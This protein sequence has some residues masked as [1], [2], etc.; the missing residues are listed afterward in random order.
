MKGYKTQVNCKIWVSIYFKISINHYYHF[1]C[2][3][4]SSVQTRNLYECNKTHLQIVDE[5]KTNLMS[6]AILFPFLCAQHVSNINICIFRSLRLCCWITTSVVLFSVRCVLELLVRLVLGG[7]RFAGWSTSVLQPAKWYATNL[8]T[9]TGYKISSWNKCTDFHR[10]YFSNCYLLG[11]DELYY[12]RWTLMLRYILPPFSGLKELGPRWHRVMKLYRR[13]SWNVANKNL[14]KGIVFSG[15]TDS[16]S[17]TP[18]QGMLH[19]K[20]FNWEN[21]VTKIIRNKPLI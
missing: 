5:W 15:G 6:L 4:V 1:V 9:F 17:P 3:Y 7:V 8:H 19:A 18:V 21:F 16:W 11:S 14:G 2:L 10:D 13:C 12:Y 20:E